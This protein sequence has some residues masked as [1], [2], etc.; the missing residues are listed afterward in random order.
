MD[1]QIAEWTDAWTLV[2][3]N[4]DADQ[5]HWDTALATGRPVIGHVVYDQAQADEAIAKGASG[6][7]G[8]LLAASVADEPINE[9]PAGQGS[10][11]WA[12]GPCPAPSSQSTDA[13]SLACTNRFAAPRASGTSS[14]RAR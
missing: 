13:R 3:L 2:G 6:A 9:S 7:D 8:Q 4:W 11:M 10:T 1:E 12:I 5:Q 14:P